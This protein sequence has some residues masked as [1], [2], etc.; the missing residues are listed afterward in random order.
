MR[1]IRV[2]EGRRLLASDAPW[3]GASTLVFRS[4]V[5]DAVGLDLSRYGELLPVSC[6]RDSLWIYNPTDVIDALDEESSSLDRF[7]DGRIM[8]IY[9][10]AFRPDVVEGKDVFKIPSR[11]I[12]PT[13]FSRRF[14]E[15]WQASGLKGLDFVEV[16][17]RRS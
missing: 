3:L 16:W 15:R 7:D 6:R 14:V 9:R 1:V 11:R 4:S 5:L 13:F 8:I 2:D 10:Y 17:P 12:S